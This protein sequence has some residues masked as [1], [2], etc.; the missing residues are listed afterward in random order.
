MENSGAKV[1]ITD[2]DVFRNNIQDT[3]RVPAI[4]TWVMVTE[5]EK[6]DGFYSLK[7]IMEDASDNLEPAPLSS[8]DDAVII[9]YTSG[10]TGVPRGAVLTDRNMMYTVRRYCL[11]L[12]IPPTNRKQLALLVMPVAH[13]S[14]HQN[15]LILLSMAIPMYFMSRFDPADVLAKIEKYR[16]TFFAGIPAMFK[17]LLKAGAEQYD[18]TSVQ[19]WG[20][21]ADAF[22]PEMGDTHQASVRPWI[23]HGGNSGA[24][25]Y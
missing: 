12:G 23:W 2:Y 5:R 19:L 25:M 1:L 21:G 10:T 13:T 18:L 6:P 16:V 24:R 7:E 17:M 22:P 4:E 8:Q 20:G 11:L 3:S 15:L 14:G 9:F